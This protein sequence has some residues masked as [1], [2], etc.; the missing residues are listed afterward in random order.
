MNLICLAFALAW[1]AAAAQQSPAPVSLVQELA[2][3]QVVKR[4]APQYPPVRLEGVVKL[5]V[6]VNTLGTVDAVEVI[7][8]HPLLAKNA[9]EAVRQWTFKPFIE[10]GRPTPFVSELD[11]PFTLNIPK[12][13]RDLRDQFQRL[14]EE[15][16]TA[17]Q[18]K[19]AAGAEKLLRQSIALGEKLPEEGYYLDLTLALQSLGRACMLQQNYPEAEKQYLRELDILRRHVNPDDAEIGSALVNLAIVYQLS[20]QPDKAEANYLQG[21]AIFEKQAAAA[22]VEEMKRNY[23]RT[24][25]QIWN[26]LGALYTEQRKQQQA[27]DTLTKALNLAQTIGYQDYVTMITASLNRLAGG[28]Y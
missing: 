20:G 23:Q 19:D 16:R 18:R 6:R 4:V 26:Q 27:R 25:V 9:V 11:I 21:A 5:R 7:S 8:G 28:R 14:V 3:K 2:L 10:Y 12:E 24:L 13:E 17:L 15:G 1:A 22:P